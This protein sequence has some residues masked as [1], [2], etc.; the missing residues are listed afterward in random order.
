MISLLFLTE[1]VKQVLED[2]DLATDV[3]QD[4]EA[5]MDQIDDKFVQSTKKWKMRLSELEFEKI[6]LFKKIYSM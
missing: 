4:M 1:R 6:N 3:R 5:Y 2:E